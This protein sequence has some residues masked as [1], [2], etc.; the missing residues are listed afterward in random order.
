MSRYALSLTRN[1]A[2]AQDLTQDTFLLAFEHWAQFRA[3][4][5]CRAW[6]FTICRNRFHRGRVRQERQVATDDADLESLA[7][8]AIHA[9]ARGAGIE[10][11]FER[12]EVIGAVEDAVAGLPEPF[13]DAVLLVDLNDH[14][15]EEASAVLGV[16]VGTVRSRLFRGRRLLQEH[17]IAHARDAGL[18]PPPHDAMAPNGGT[19]P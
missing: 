5:E 15:Y 17:L 13:R 6:L 8:A 18:I 11:L 16:P 12:D 14:S 1:E 3:G 4:T 2:E 19:K 10:D 7:A 9:S